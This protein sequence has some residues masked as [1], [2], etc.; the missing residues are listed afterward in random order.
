MWWAL[1][2]YSTVI[3]TLLFCCINLDLV[4][5]NG[6]YVSSIH[7]LKYLEKPYQLWTDLVVER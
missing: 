6:S 4:C 2:M 3:A 5:I 1:D 7:R